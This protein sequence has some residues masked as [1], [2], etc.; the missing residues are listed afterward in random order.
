MTLVCDKI[1]VCRLQ[2]SYCPDSMLAVLI[3]LN[4]KKMYF[5]RK[6]SK[7]DTFKMTD[8]IIIISDIGLLNHDIE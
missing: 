7:C 2:F 6:C 3:D 1:A 4:L 5:M 8:L